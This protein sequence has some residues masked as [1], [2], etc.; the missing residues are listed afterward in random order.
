MV[1]TAAHTNLPQPLVSKQTNMDEIHHFLRDTKF[2]PGKTV[3]N[4]L[5]GYR[6]RNYLLCKI[7][8]KKEKSTLKRINMLIITTL[9]ELML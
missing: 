3:K 1:A 8:I 4:C 5:C 6:L 7:L 2:F 9:T